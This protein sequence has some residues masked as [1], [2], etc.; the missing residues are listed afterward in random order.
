[1][2]APLFPLTNIT[3]N[4]TAINPA[5]NVTVSGSVITPAGINSTIL[6]DMKALLGGT[7]SN[8]T[9]IGPVSSIMDDAFIADLA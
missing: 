5:T 4:G 8:T 1:M 3:A 7:C 2:I 9:P 6:A